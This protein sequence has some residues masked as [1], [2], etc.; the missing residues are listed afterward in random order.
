[1]RR[2]FF[3]IS[4]KCSL[5]ALVL[6]GLAALANAATF[7]VTNT[8]DSGAGS[9]RQAI[10]DA[11]T[12]STADTIVFDSSF[13]VPRTI[14]LG[15]TQMNTN[16]NAT[17]TLT[18]NGPGSNLL[19]VSGNNASPI[20]FVQTG[21]LA[22]SGMTV[23]QGRATG[24][25]AF[26]GALYNGGISLTLTNMTISASSSTIDGGGIYIDTGTLTMTNCIVTGNSATRSGGGIALDT[27]TSATVIDSQIINNSSLSTNPTNGT[28]GGGIWIG[29]GSSGTTGTMTLNNST[30]SNNTST[31]GASGGGIFVATRAT[32]NINGSTVSGNTATGDGGGIAGQDAA[33]NLTNATISG[34]NGR[35]G[36]GV[37]R[38]FGANLNQAN[39]DYCTVAGN[40]GT[41]SGG[42]IVTGTLNPTNFRGSI[43]ADNTSPSGPDISGPGVSFGYNLFESTSGA[44]ITGVPTGNIIGQDP[45][46]FPLA[47]TGGNV[48]THRIGLGSPALDAGDPGTFPPLDARG[49][50]RAVDGDGN[51]TTVPDIGAF[52][53]RPGLLQFSSPSFSVLENVVGG[54]AALIVT[55]TNGSD[56]DVTVQFAT[57][58]GTA[59]GGGVDYQTS[60]GMIT[61]GNQITSQ[62]IS[63][64]IVNDILTEPD[65][66]VNISLMAPGLGAKL[67]NPSAT[68]LTILDND[69]TVTVGGKVTTPNGQPIRSIP[70]DLV[71]SAG[72]IRT[73][74][75]SPFGLYSFDNVRT[76]ETYTIRARS[77]RYRFSPI[78]MQ[79]SS[80]V[81]NLDLPG[82]E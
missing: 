74:N 80:S 5:I 28:G 55:R 50:T 37:H 70:V 24:A 6:C 35:N 43:I 60:S 76:G 17:N 14:T 64:P 81:T 65:E 10:L 32:L 56:G 16:G 3:R 30:V 66:T 38:S 72:I 73:T 11:N 26:G 78:V 7:T 62:V 67:G 54:N 2:L 46:L 69:V 57:S 77:K 58:D 49:F 15:G 27:A 61:V 34:N 75:S 52:E 8:N 41:T 63:I 51:G 21:V 48:Q 44:T 40:T 59:T 36:G 29:G 20:F 42:G 18:I 53:R 4:I 9:L 22:L 45:G 19:T 31:A 39:F 33:L 23:T 12:A 25:F 82:L 1:M 47:N 13:N 68:V 71:D 79:F